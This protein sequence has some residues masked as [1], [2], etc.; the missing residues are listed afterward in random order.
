MI[1]DTAEIRT[2]SPWVK[3]RYRLVSWWD[4][5]KFSAEDFCKI[6]HVLCILE[7]ELENQPAG[8]EMTPKDSLCVTDFL[9]PQMSD[10]CSKIGLSMVLKHIDLICRRLEGGI[11]F[12]AA[13]DLISTLGREVNFEMEGALFLHIPAL[14][15][16]Y[17]TQ[18]EALFGSIARDVFPLAIYDAD[19]SGKCLALE[20][21]TACVFHLMR[22]MEVG[23]KSLSELAGI[24]YAPSWES[25]L[26]QISDL[27]KEKWEKKD[28]EW[29]RGEPFFVEAAGH[30]SSVK[31][32][33][34]NPTMH[35]ARNYSS[36]EAKEVFVSVRTFI[37][38]L[39]AHLS[40]QT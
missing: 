24:P 22:V 1:A 25:Y 35:V 23:L 13:R 34:R 3:D 36:E 20:R 33:W 18:K 11:T 19:E 15:A 8:Q 28:P 6:A 38:H 16:P 17:Y 14:D 12:Q 10:A 39:A 40:E 9:K 26:K 29:K 21:T 4:M 37:R 7:H 30:L 32:A 2:L 5:E 31:I 27:Y